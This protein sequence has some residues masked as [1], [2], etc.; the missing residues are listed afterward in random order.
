M[1]DDRFA[2]LIFDREDWKKTPLASFFSFSKGNHN[3]DRHVDEMG[4]L[5]AKKRNLF[6][7]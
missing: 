3:L 6:K 5:H 7:T 1:I 4:L 2:L